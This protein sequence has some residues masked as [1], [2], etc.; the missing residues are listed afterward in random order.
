MKK[1]MILLAVLLCTN[2][3]FAQDFVIIVNPASKLTSISSNDLKKIY[4]G[5]TSLIGK[6]K[7]TPINLVD[8]DPIYSSFIN[9]IV[10]MTPAAYKQYWVDAQIKGE[11]TA[12]V[13]QR[14]SQ[15]AKLIVASLPEAIAYV[16]ASVVDASVK[17][18]KIK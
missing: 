9:K 1:I 2:V 7:V 16:D 6:Q 15:A 3:L 13:T 10:K 12:P 17:I 18:I 4:L 14:N 8:V 5:K 11:G